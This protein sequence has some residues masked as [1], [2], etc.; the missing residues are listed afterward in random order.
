MRN[1]LEVEKIVSISAFKDMWFTW[2]NELNHEEAEEIFNEFQ[3][4]IQYEID[5]LFHSFY[6][7][8]NLEKTQQQLIELK[9]DLRSV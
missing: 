6:T 4:E 9:A 1:K 8:R 7:K 3:L 2:N 5:K